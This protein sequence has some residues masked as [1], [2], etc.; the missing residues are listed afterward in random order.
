MLV[1]KGSVTNMKREEMY[2]I[3]GDI[4]SKYLDEAWDTAKKR[5]THA[6]FLRLLPAAALVAIV[7]VTLLAV[8]PFMRAPA[9]TLEPPVPPLSPDS[10]VGS[11]LEGKFKDISYVK[12]EDH[13]TVTE[14]LGSSS[15]IEI[16]SEIGGVPVTEVEL[17]DDML[18]GEPV[19]VEI[20]IDSSNLAILSLSSNYRVVLKIGKNVTEL[21][22]SLLHCQEVISVEV[23][24]ENAVYASVDGI[25]YSKD[26]KNLIACPS[27]R[28]IQAVLSENSYDGEMSE[29]E[30]NHSRSNSSGG[31]WEQP[32]VKNSVEFNRAFLPS[33]LKNVEGNA[34]LD[35]TNLKSII[36]PEGVKDIA[37]NAFA[38]CRNLRELY[39]PGTLSNASPDILRDCTGLMYLRTSLS[40]KD[41]EKLHIE[42]PNSAKVFTALPESGDKELEKEIV[43]LYEQAEKLVS[44]F[45]EFNNIPCDETNI[46]GEYRMVTDDRV[47]SIEDLKKLLSLCF[48]ENFESLFDL[49]NAEKP[50]FQ[51]YDGNLYVFFKESPV[52]YNDGQRLYSLKETENGLELTVRTTVNCG[53]TSV[54]VDCFYTLTET[55]NGYRFLSPFTLPVQAWYPFYLVESN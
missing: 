21:N 47:H 19:N 1:E 6:V 9:G 38:R 11:P 17:C 41:F 16:P 39:L 20:R 3:L 23:D 42:I 24:G 5:K 8:L 2:K 12:Y 36:L 33:E 27:G 4:D 44:W 25:L 18:N 45:S 40:K 10:F 29:I 52:K 34:F 53:T 49:G 14:Y 54:T 48:A 35:C 46:H 51:E 13:A 22:T 37:P 55:E 43:A 31:L 15:V 32:G 50:L 26:L 30:K 7:C 28:K